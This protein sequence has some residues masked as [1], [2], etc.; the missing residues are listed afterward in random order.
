[1][2]RF[3]LPSKNST[4]YVEDQNGNR[5]YFSYFG[6]LEAAKDA[7]ETLVNCSN[8]TNCRDCWG[9]SYSVNCYGC[10]N[11][12]WCRGCTSCSNSLSLSD[13]TGCSNCFGCSESRELSSCSDCQKC[14]GC[15]WLKG[16]T[17][18]N[19]KHGGSLQIP[20]IE[21]I[22]QKVYDRA[23]K[24]GCLKME[25]WH[26]S[27]DAHCWAGWITFL[28]GEPAK[29]LED[30]FGSFAVGIVAQ[31]ILSENSKPQIPHHLF[32]IFESQALTKMKELADQEKSL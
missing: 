17:N 8:C 2:N 30:F 25:K 1:M 5:N 20:K 3:K 18:R 32:L 23:S 13:C 6:S 9:C 12:R 15:S 29:L 7:L 22:H 4:E 21:N 11:C 31:M 14:S 27:K 10:S 16:T 26:T 28:G 19:D 24:P